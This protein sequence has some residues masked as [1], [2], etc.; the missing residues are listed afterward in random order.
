M[1]VMR[2]YQVVGRR[3][4]DEKVGAN[5]Q[6]YRMKLFARDAV[7]AKSRF[8]Y[9]LSKLRKMKRS[10][11]DVLALNEIKEK[12]PTL[13]KNFALWIRYDSRSGTHNV[14]KEY[15]DT[16][17]TGAVDKMYAEF[18]SRHRAR[19]RSIH[20]IRTAIRPAGDCIRPAVTT[21]HNQKIKFPLP[22]RVTS[23]VQKS[24][25]VAKG[26]GHTHQN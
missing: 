20:I 13:V 23:T 8:W 10:T 2:H 15:R 4:P 3:R 17:L 1:G 11:G 21:F 18:A 24:A 6:I 7:H 26:A 16:H 9:F 19:F 12:K 25:I 5:P 22:H 14:Y